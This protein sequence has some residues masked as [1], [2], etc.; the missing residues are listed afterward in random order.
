[1][2][3]ID[4]SNVHSLDRLTLGK[5]GKTDLLKS[6]KLAGTPYVKYSKRVSEGLVNLS[7]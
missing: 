7:N 4:F 6:M 5:S 1:M 3:E 2:A